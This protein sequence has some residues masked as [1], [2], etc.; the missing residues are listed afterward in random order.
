MKDSLLPNVICGF[1]GTTIECPG[2]KRVIEDIKKGLKGVILMSWNNKSQEQMGLLISEF[3]K[4]N[5]NLIISV[6]HEG[7]LV[8][9]DRK[10]DSQEEKQ[11]FPKQLDIAKQSEKEIE[12][13]YRQQAK[14]LKELG[15]THVFAPVVDL[16]DPCSKAIGKFGRAFSADPIEIARIASIAIEQYSGAGIV[17]VLKHFPGH[18]LAVGDT[19]TDSVSSSFNSIELAPYRLL[20][21][22]IDEELLAILAQ[23]NGDSLEDTKNRVSALAAVSSPE[24]YQVMVA[25]VKINGIVASLSKE[26]KA[27]LSEIYPS[28]IKTVTDCICM[29][30]I[31]IAKF[32]EKFLAEKFKLAQDCNLLCKFFPEAKTEAVKVSDVMGL[33]EED[34]TL[35]LQE[36]FKDNS[37][38]QNEAV[39][40]EVVAAV[41]DI[42]ADINILGHT[43]LMCHSE[44]FIK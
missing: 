19:H 7:G 16:H 26:V 4:H 39:R 42:A 35:K 31:I 27:K 12:K 3:L 25:H 15:I 24:Y 34:I 18:G 30:A 10:F 43:P 20:S 32:V 40:Q 44:Y 9:F 21:G 13:I 5:P 29:H 41:E 14:R 36:Y 23:H 22:N 6:D 17:P 2:T 28:G 11:F 37:W 1:Y 38:K 33:S 8:N